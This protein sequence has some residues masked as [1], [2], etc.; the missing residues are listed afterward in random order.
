M[1]LQ[2]PGAQIDHASVLRVDNRLQR[3]LGPVHAVENERGLSNPPTADVV[4]VLIWL[5]SHVAERAYGDGTKS[6]E[7][8]EA[9]KLLDLRGLRELR[10]SS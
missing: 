9:K 7:G 4:E 3:R 5:V 8:P 2:A 6:H 1:F 10:G